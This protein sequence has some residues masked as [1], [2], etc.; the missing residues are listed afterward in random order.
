M[1]FL[2]LAVSGFC[3][4]C[5]VV[6]FFVQTVSVFS[7]L[8]RLGCMHQYELQCAD[9]IHVGMSRFKSHHEVWYKWSKWCV[10]RVVDVTPVHISSVFWSRV[11]AKCVRNDQ[12]GM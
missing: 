9:A 2:V 4:L 6:L 7:L 8:R 11:I 12:N 5:E 10:I 1:L 3:V